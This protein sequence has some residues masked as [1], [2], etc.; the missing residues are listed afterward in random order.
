MHRVNLDRAAAAVKKFVRSLPVKNGGVELE[1]DGKVLCRVTSPKELT[2]REKSELLGRVKKHL[3]RS[4]HRNRNAPVAAIER[5][6][7]QAV[8]RVRRDR[9]S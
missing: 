2:E 5:E 7:E 8:K 3:A 4:H 6:V 9:K 1:L